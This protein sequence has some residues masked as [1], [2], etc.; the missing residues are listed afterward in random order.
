MDSLTPGF[1][2]FFWEKADLVNVADGGFLSA[3]LPSWASYNE[4]LSLQVLRNFIP[5]PLPIPTCAGTV[6]KLSHCM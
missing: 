6:P 3:S 2:G 1:V 5:L 4:N